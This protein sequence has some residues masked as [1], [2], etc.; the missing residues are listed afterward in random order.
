MNDHGLSHQLES[1]IVMLGR[2]DDNSYR[3]PS[4][5]LGGGSI[6]QHVRHVVGLVQCMVTGYRSGLID[7]DAR[8]RDPRTEA[9]RTFAI[10]QLKQVIIDIPFE[11]KNLQLKGG[12]TAPGVMVT[13]TRREL[14]YNADHAIHHMALMRVALRE[15]KLEVVDESFGKAPATLD[16]EQASKALTA[17]TNS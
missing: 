15:L 3:R 5:M 8:I 16:F 11:D 1:I 7:Y 2:I 4:V 17:L 14:A 6:G 13:T 10:S 9:E 12:V